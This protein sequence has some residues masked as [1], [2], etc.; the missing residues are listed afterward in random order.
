MILPLASAY[1]LF[2]ATL[3]VQE[4]EKVEEYYDVYEKITEIEPILQQPELYHPLAPKEAVEEITNGQVAITLYNKDGYMLYSSKKETAPVI[5]KK[6]VLYQDL[7]DVQ[8]NLGTYSYKEPVLEDGNII[9]FYE[10]TIAREEFTEKVTNR[11]FIVTTIFIAS[12][13]AIY[14]LVAF[15]LHHRVNK[16]LTE[17]MDE[18]T[19]FAEGESLPETKT[20]SDEI[21]ELKRRFYEMRTQIEEAQKLVKQEQED[22][23]YTVATISHDLKTPL[24]SI[25]AYT[26]ALEYGDDLTT[27]EQ[28]QYRE[29][30]ME[31]SDFMKQMLDDLL[32]HTLLQ[33]RTYELDVV[34]VDGDEFFDMI[35]SDYEALADEKQITLM[36]ENHVIGDYEVSPKQI[37]RVVDNLMSNAIHHT[38]IQGKIWLSTF[39]EEVDIPNWLFEYVAP[40]YSFNTEKYMYIIVQN[41]GSGISEVNQKLLFDPLYQ[42]DQ[43]RS[44]KIAHGTGLGLSISQVIIEKHGG[45]ISVRSQLNE[46]ACFISALPKKKARKNKEATS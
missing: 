41:E 14:A 11:G 16:R 43:A 6:D 34:T 19:A 22:K 38:P 28:K 7:F 27:E 20:G 25:I 13:I 42:V 26:E 40:S 44:K 10:V 12:F 39:S 30:I 4:E 31:K 23:E 8:Q 35:I 18:M 37:M 29:I 5:T 15:V 9:G 17:L 45:T 1:Y 32:T 33:S 46:G 36:T 21:G 2:A 24:T 3:N